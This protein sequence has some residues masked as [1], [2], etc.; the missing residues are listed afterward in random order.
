MATEKKKVARAPLKD[1]VLYMAFKGELQGEPTFA[2]D[3]D[4]LIDRMLEDRDLKVKK[5]TIPRNSRKKKDAAAS[6]NTAA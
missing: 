3:K 5:I 1:R 2:F 4:A 6:V